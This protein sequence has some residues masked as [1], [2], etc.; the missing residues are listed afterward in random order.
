MREAKGVFWDKGFAETSLHHLEEQTAVR[1]S[2]L[3]SKFRAK[4]NRSLSALR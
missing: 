2:G 4:D 1:T 3:H